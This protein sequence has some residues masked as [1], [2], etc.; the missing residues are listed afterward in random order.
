LTKIPGHFRVLQ[1]ELFSPGYSRFS[2]G[3]GNPA[4]HTD[5]TIHW[6]A[7]EEEHFLII[8]FI[9]LFYIQ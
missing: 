5:R 6:K 2:R 9:S 1:E 8:N 4:E 3:C 7:L